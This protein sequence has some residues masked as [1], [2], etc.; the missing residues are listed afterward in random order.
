MPLSSAEPFGKDGIIPIE[1]ALLSDFERVC[2]LP[3]RNIFHFY[4]L[5]ITSSV[6]LIFTQKLLSFF[7]KAAYLK[8]VNCTEPSKSVLPKPQLTVAKLTY[9]GCAIKDISKLP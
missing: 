2:K 7:S 4:I 6:T 5:F 1:T 9:L 8:E 3:L